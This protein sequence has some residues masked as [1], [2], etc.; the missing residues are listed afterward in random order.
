MRI[1]PLLDEKLLFNRKWS[2]ILHVFFWMFVYLDV[3]LDFEYMAEDWD[4]FLKSLGVQAGIV[5]LNLYVLFPKLFLK[6][7]YI[8]YGLAT[9]VCVFCIM[10]IDFWMFDPFY[11]IPKAEILP[12]YIEHFIYNAFIMGSAIGLKLFKTLLKNRIKLDELRKLKHSAELNYLKN[13]INPHF[14]F[15]AMN[16]MY[17]LSQKNSA[18]LSDS[19]LDLS[20]LMRYQLHEGQKPFV[21]IGEEVKFLKNYVKFED[22]RRTDLTVNFHE[23]IE[24]EGLNIA[25]LLLLAFIENAMKHSKT[26]DDRPVVVDIT[27]S[28]NKAEL[29]CKVTNPIGDYEAAKNDPNKGIGLKNVKRRLDILYPDKHQLE[30]KDSGDYFSVSLTI[31][32]T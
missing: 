30:I 22:M 7:K 9:M 1:M 29:F 28:A 5:Y 13:Q 15:N 21:T 32:N 6:K 4:S 10:I 12:Y 31:D 11:D 18:Q 16:S 14:L 19:I 20:D 17:V 8:I 27:I 23:N 2:W 24:D 26:L 3:L 25:P